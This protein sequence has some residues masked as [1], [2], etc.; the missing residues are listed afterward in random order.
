MLKIARDGNVTDSAE[1]LAEANAGLGAEIAEHPGTGELMQGVEAPADGTMSPL[2]GN[3]VPGTE[4]F[5]IEGGSAVPEG[6]EVLTTPAE[7]A[8]AAPAP[9]VP[10]RVPPRRTPP[11]G[12]PGD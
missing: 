4:A 12:A 11:P 7:G 3:A 8:A 2:V 6:I 10:S 1:V 5:M 9:A